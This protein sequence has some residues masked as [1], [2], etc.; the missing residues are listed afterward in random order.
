MRLVSLS[1][2]GLSRIGLHA[3][4]CAA[5]AVIQRKMYRLDTGRS[6]AASRYLNDKDH[7]PSGSAVLGRC[8]RRR[9]PGRWSSDCA[10]HVRRRTTA[11]CSCPSILSEINHKPMPARSPAGHHFTERVQRKSPRAE[12]GRTARISLG[13]QG[14]DF[15]VPADFAPRN[16]PAWKIRRLKIIRRASVLRDQRRE[17]R[18]A[19]S[20]G[21]RSATLICARGADPSSRAGLQVWH[22]VQ[23]PPGQCRAPRRWLQ[24]FAPEAPVVSRYAVVG[25]VG[26]QP[27][28]PP[29]AG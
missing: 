1:R 27:I 15:C 20:R 10:Y 11:G 25:W 5:S 9:W 7:T 17:A 12:L 16:F 29:R 24:A 6:W 23:V 26:P 8:S 21:H 28:E 22:R 14:V 19:T 3:G 2:F 18:P 13:I 4:L